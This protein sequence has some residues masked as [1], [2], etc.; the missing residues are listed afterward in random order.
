MALLTAGCGTRDKGVT[1]TGG[2]SEL[3]HTEKMVDLKSLQG[4][5]ELTSIEA[6]A[7]AYDKAR[8]WRSDAVLWYLMP[9]ADSL[10]DKWQEND[11]AF[12]WHVF[13]VNK[14]DNKR[15][16]IKIQGNQVIEASEDQHFFRTTDIPDKLPA[17]RPG[18][19]MKEAA[20]AAFKDDFP[21]NIKPLIV[22]DHE[23][24]KFVG[25]TIWEFTFNLELNGKRQGYRY[26]VDGLTGKLLE[27]QGENEKPVTPPDLSRLTGAQQ[28][29]QQGSKGTIKKFFSLMDQ[30]NL[31]QAVSC[32]DSEMAGSDQM[33]QMWKDSLGTVESIKITGIEENARGDW[34]K[35]K[36][37]YKVNL[38]VTLKPGS[39]FMGW[40]EGTNTRW[41]EMNSQDGQWK[42]HQLA[43][44]P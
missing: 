18:I 2:K 13:F 7:L 16:Y 29:P 37:L 3:A 30:G 34:N 6:A 33:K 20:R 5:N 24:K 10:S 21:D 39:Q 9:P 32:M 15:Y 19:S 40:G 28:K 31:D 4:K 8:K 36:E 43:G 23:D 42:L 14:S 25:R 1:S 11:T 35:N 38:Q 12:S 22:Y 17:G 44:N 26:I 41:V 27:V